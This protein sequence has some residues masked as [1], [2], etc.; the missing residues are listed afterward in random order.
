MTS[1][2]LDTLDHEQATN[3]PIQGREGTLQEPL[4]GTVWERNLFGYSLYANYHEL[5]WRLLKLQLR[6]AMRDAMSPARRILVDKAGDT[7][8]R[9]RQWSN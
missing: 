2:L 3:K 6:V 8:T 7:G 1:G 4:Q 5:G 9:M